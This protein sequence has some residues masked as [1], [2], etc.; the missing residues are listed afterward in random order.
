[1]T[2]I[3]EEMVDTACDAFDN[4]YDGV[5]HNKRDAIRECITAVAPL[6]QAKVADGWQLVPVEPTNE[7]ILAWVCSITPN[8]NTNISDDDANRIVATADWSAMLAAAPEVQS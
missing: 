8:F 6:M 3:T 2:E 1:M 4:I 7:M 5:S